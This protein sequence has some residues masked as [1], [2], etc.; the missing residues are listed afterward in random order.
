VTPA[1]SPPGIEDAAGIAAADADLLRRAAAVADHPGLETLSANALRMLAERVG[2]DL[3]TAVLYDRVRRSPRHTP[4]VRAVDARRAKL[5]AS[6]PALHPILKSPPAADVTVGV[7]P[8]AFWRHHSNTGADGQQVFDAAARLG[9]SCARVPM[10]SLGSL[11]E[12][13]AVLLGWLAGRRS[14]P[15]VVLVSLSKGGADVKAA[16]A[17]AAAERTAAADFGRVVAWASLSGTLQGTPLVRWLRDRPLRCW[18]VRALLA[19]RGLPFAAVDELARAETAPLWA[20]PTLPPGLRLIHV[21]GFPLRRHL[22]HPWAPRAYERVAPLG[23]NDGGGVLLGDLAG[24]PGEVY[25]VWGADHYLRP[26]G[27]DGSL[28][29]AVLAEAVAGSGGVSATAPPLL[30]SRQAHA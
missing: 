5:S 4:L 25:A 1:G 17:I 2:I 8:G 29:A 7:V 15:P 14:G 26:P 11:W 6:A 3:A 13:A 20:W 28:L 24:W 27:D 18:G 30:P 21:A 23:P 9:L 12:N 16:L 19:A 10:P 22:A